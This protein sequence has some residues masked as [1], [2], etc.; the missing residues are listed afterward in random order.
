VGK[1]TLHDTVGIA[2][3]D[4]IESLLQVPAVNAAGPS[5][6]LISVPEVQSGRKSVRRRRALYETAE[7]VEPYHKRPRMVKENMIQSGRPKKEG[8]STN[9]SS[10]KAAGL[11]M[12]IN[13]KATPMWTEWD[14]TFVKDALPKL[15]MRKISY[16]PQLKVSPTSISTVVETLNMSKRIAEECEQKYISV[17]YD[18]AIA[19]IALTIQSEERPEFDNFFVQLGSF[20]IERARSLKLS[21]NSLL[22]PVDRIF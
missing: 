1:D 10:C 9:P 12:D 2:Y 14:A 17:T 8:Y 6:E 18:L 13:L 3:Q 4:E 15:P 21:A 19:N 16:L 20:H 5:V 11:H 22:I 7:V